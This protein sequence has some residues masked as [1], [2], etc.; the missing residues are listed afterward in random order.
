[1]TDQTDTTADDAAHAQ[2]V[3]TVVNSIFE[4]VPAFA[5]LGASPEMVFEGAVKAGAAVLMSGAGASRF[6]VAELLEHMAAGFRVTHD[7]KRGN[8]HVVE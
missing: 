4:L 1:M 6:D 5:R 2:A 3:D 8:L 7:P